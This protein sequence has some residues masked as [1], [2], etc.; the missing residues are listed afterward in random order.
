ALEP[1][2]GTARKQGCHVTLTHHAGKADRPDGDDIL[3]ST[4]LLGGVDTTI[5]IKKRDTRRTFSTIQRYHKDNEEDL[6]ET[7][8]ELNSDGSL[9]VKGTRQ[10]VEIEETMLL[11]VE[12]LKVGET[13]TINDLYD[14][15]EKSKSLVS[16]A[17]DRLLKNGTIFRSG[18]GKKGDAYKY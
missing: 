1:I 3:G 15:I 8:I 5:L 11:V 18:S 17:V 9:S 2:L 7:V 6:P 10:D 14:Q 13:P 12:T 4:G 16:K